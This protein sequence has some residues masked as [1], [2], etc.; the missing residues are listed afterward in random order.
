M[1][2]QLTKFWKK[3]RHTRKVDLAFEWPASCDGWKELALKDLLQ[4]L[5]YVCEFD[6]CAFGVQTTAGEALRKRWR[7]RAT[8]QPLC[9]HLQRQC[10]G[11]R[12][13][14][15]RG[16]D[17]TQAGYYTWQLAE[18]VVKAILDN[19]VAPVDTPATLEQEMEENELEEFRPPEP[20][21]P[22]QE[23]ALPR[24]PRPLVGPSLE[25]WNAH[26]A[27][28]VPFRAWCRWCVQNRGKEDPHRRVASERLGLVPHIELDYSFVKFA[29]SERVR[30]ILAV[31]YVQKCYSFAAVVEGK[32]SEDPCAPKMVLRF[33]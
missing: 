25:E 12:H 30:P 26:Q 21:R 14:T 24:V 32:G 29:G 3:V 4:D 28:H 7:V 33:L 18:A 5:P 15:V 19:C 13:A 17:A 11:Q 23:P 8:F 9:D 10:R 6:G 2:A 27:T 1:I 16:R 22:E 31:T 20:R